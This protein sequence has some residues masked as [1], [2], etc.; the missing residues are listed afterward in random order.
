MVKLSWAMVHTLL[1]SV[2]D[3]WLE[4]LESFVIKFNNIQLAELYTP[5]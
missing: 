4:R 5:H 2:S 3:I 1:S